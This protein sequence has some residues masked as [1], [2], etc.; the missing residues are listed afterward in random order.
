MLIGSRFQD[1]LLMLDEYFIKKYP[2]QINYYSPNKLII[3]NYSP[4]KLII[5]L[6]YTQ[7]FTHLIC[8]KCPRE[9]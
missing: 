8:E 3:Y 4:N 7:I 9:V 5:I 6:L 2:F 1:T